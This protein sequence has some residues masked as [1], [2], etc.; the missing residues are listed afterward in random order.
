MAITN[1][2]PDVRLNGA[3]TIP[4]TCEK[5]NIGRDQLREL[6]NEGKINSDNMRNSKET[7]IYY[8]LDILRFWFDQTNQHKDDVELIQMLR[9]KEA[10]ILAISRGKG[11]TKRAYSSTSR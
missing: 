2:P 1:I 5:L 10:D 6:T 8:A 3:Y 7:I 4:E 11:K 9:D